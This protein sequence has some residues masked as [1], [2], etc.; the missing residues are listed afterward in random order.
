MNPR[1]VN[2]GPGNLHLVLLP[3]LV[4][5]CL[6]PLL[7]DD[8]PDDNGNKAAELESVRNQIRDVESEMQVSRSKIDDLQLELRINEITAGDI[9]LALKEIKK[10]F[11]LKK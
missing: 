10:E 9:T 5:F 7:A 6:S 8:Q 11:A 4:F 2:G 3:A 1:P